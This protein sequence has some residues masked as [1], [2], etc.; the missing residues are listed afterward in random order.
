MDF[1]PSNLFRYDS[2]PGWWRVAAPPAG[3]STDAQEGQMLHREMAVH[4]D[5]VDWAYRLTP[6][7]RGLCEWAWGEVSEFATPSTS[8]AETMLFWDELGMQGTADLIVRDGEDLHVIDWKFGRAEVEDAQ[9]NLQLAAYAVMASKG[10]RVDGAII[11]HI[12]QPRLRVHTQHAF[13]PAQLAEAERQII[14]IKTIAECEDAP[15]RPGSPQCDWCP[16]KANCPALAQVA[17]SS[18]QTALPA[19]PPEQLAN[20]A[21]TA[22]LARKWAD[23]VDA[24]LKRRLLTGEVIPGYRLQGRKERELVSIAAA[25]RQLG[26]PADEF[27]ACCKAS[28]PKIVEAYRTKKELGEREAKAEVY[29]LL[30]GLAEE[31]ETVAIK[32]EARK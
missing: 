17:A 26:L 4:A 12:V 10:F 3:D 7:H 16:A 21:D 18:P 2:C 6:E 28:L 14:G 30:D 15:L 27:L 24:E 1:R 9:D 23:A 25:F 8:V 32:R 13:N 11:V 29:L 22:R 31:V 19:M 20:Y 5:G